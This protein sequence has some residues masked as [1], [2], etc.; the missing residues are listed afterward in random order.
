MKKLTVAVI[1]G[2]ASSEYE[3]SLQSSTSVLNNISHETFDVIMLGITKD[4]RWLRY[5]G[6]VEKIAQNQWNQPEYVTPAFISPDRSVHGIVELT[7][8]GAVVTPIDAAFP[9]LHGKNGEDGT[10]QGL[11]ELAGIPYV[12]CGVCA[13]A[14]C[15]DKE[16][17]HT[18]LDRN[19]IANAK[20][21]A[22]KRQ[23]FTDPDATAAMLEEALGYPMFVKPANAG[24]SVGVS[25]ASDKASLLQALDLAFQHDSKAIV[26][27]CIVGQEVETAVLGNEDPKAALVGEIVPKVEF[28]TYDAKYADD[29][30]DLY[31]P[32]HITEE[33]ADRL[34]EIAIQAYKALGCAGMTRMDFFVKADGS[35]ILNEP[36]TI[37]GFTS[38]SMYPKLWI[39]AGL[40]YD[41]L[42]DRLIRLAM[43]R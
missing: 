36:N 32:A 41:Q 6:P 22:V 23:D 7:P 2:G 1:F 40:P 19:G 4:G 30:T 28:Y 14:V 43:E 31:I 13:S 12:G 9:V 5:T 21:K 26:E 37:P 3:V 20:W 39:A 27:E 33:T 8:G 42:I 18:V 11:F 15:M 17:A 10:I 25:K 16:M 38:I 35:I 24:S 34:R 29:S